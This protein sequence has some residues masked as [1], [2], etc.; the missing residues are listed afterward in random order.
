MSLELIA[1]IFALAIRL[2]DSARD[3]KRCMGGCSHVT[4]A[5]ILYFSFLFLFPF[6]NRIFDAFFFFFFGLEI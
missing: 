6:F 1:Y 2:L 5:S 4:D 3:F